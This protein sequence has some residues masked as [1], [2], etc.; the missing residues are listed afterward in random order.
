MADNTNPAP[1]TP[2]ELL[3]GTEDI[4]MLGTMLRGLLTLSE[5]IEQLRNL[6]AEEPAIR[7]RNDRL[8]R[9]AEPAKELIAQ[10]DAAQRKLDH[11]NAEHAGHRAKMRDE[12]NQVIE[13]ARAEAENI[14]AEG[15]T[16]AD[17][18]LSDGRAA[19]AAEAEAHATEA[20][21]RQEII[22]GLNTQ[23]AARNAEIAQR[24]AEFD[25]I[26]GEIAALRAKI[27]VR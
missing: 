5:K 17:Q 10:A 2:S 4:E 24:Q 22:D 20:R 18:H 13:A 16:R 1:L 8:R 11:L 25:R 27:G 12:R 9:E 23:I 14:R 15:R 3:R 21:R 26:N 19:I 7:E 6:L